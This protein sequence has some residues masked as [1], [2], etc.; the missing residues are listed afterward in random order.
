LRGVLAALSIGTLAG[1]ASAF[2]VRA[3]DPESGEA[4]KQIECG[5]VEPNGRSVYG[6]FKG[7]WYRG[8]RAPR[9][10]DILYV[11]RRGY[12]LAQVTLTPETTHRV[13]RGQAE[14]ASP[15]PCTPSSGSG[16]SDATAR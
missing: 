6:R 1:A 8:D 4:M 14:R 15:S 3:I 5:L 16:G 13:S 12:D 9:P 11:Y 2:G 7:P 10:G